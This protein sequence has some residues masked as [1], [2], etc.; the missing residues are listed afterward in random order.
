M[1]VVPEFTGILAFVLMELRGGK[2]LY[3]CRKVKLMKT[4]WNLNIILSPFVMGIPLSTPNFN[5]RQDQLLFPNE[6]QIL[7]VA[8]FVGSDVDSL[9][10]ISVKY[11]NLLINVLWNVALLQI[12]YKITAN[13]GPRDIYWAQLVCRSWFCFATTSSNHPHWFVG[14]EF[15]VRCVGSEERLHQLAM[16]HQ[17]QKFGTSS[18][19]TFVS[20]YEC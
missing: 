13:L 4:F 6:V 16:A 7:I 14:D 11:W 15:G 3:I 1:H 9:Q 17:Q 12:L 5:P 20:L 2:N 19:L 8:L 18:W 10:D